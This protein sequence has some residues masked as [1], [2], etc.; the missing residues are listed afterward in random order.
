M[1]FRGRFFLRTILLLLLIGIFA[2]VAGRWSYNA[3]WT[4]G[5]VTAQS[6]ARQADG[7][8][9]APPVAPR[10]VPYR[11]WGFGPLGWFFG[12]LLKFWLFLLLAGLTLKLLFGGGRHLHGHG[13][14]RHDHWHGPHER[15]GPR[16]KGPE[17]VEPDI[18]TA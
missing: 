14:R 6:G 16:E 9:A 15:G 1:F 12:G 7:E 8:E 2:S 13:Y 18:H 5:Y 3:G 10:P 4:D 17:D 11:G